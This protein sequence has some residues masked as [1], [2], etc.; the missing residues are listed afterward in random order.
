MSTL[1]IST[2]VHIT[3][4]KSDIVKRCNDKLNPEI[5]ENINKKTYDE[6]I[7]SSN[8]LADIIQW[9]KKGD[10]VFLYNKYKKRLIY[11]NKCTKIEGGF[12]K[13]DD[14]ICC[15]ECKSVP[16]ILDD[17]EW[18]YYIEQGNTKCECI[19]NL[20]TIEELIRSNA[21]NIYMYTV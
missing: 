5:L 9:L 17:G 7:S 10:I 13:F 19:S 16:G 20:E 1:D 14:R 21:R 6:P 15:I 2:D 12:S 8:P 11:H 3:S 4:D 18:D